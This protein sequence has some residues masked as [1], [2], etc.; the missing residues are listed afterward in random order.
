MKPNQEVA[1]K[2]VQSCS[3]IIQFMFITIIGNCQNCCE[4]DLLKYPLKSISIYCQDTSNKIPYSVQYLY[5]DN[6]NQLLLSKSIS[7]RNS[8]T[9]IVEYKFNKNRLLASKFS[10]TIPITERN[11]HRQR[12]RIFKYD[13]N[14]NLIFDGYEE[15]KGENKGYSENKSY[16]YSK[17]NGKPISSN[18]TYGPNHFENTYEYDSL[19]RLIKLYKNK[20]LEAT[21]EYSNDLLLKETR[22]IKG[23][24]YASATGTRVLIY[25]YDDSGL[26]ILKKQFGKIV[27]KNIYEKGRLLERLT[28][29]YGPD[30]NFS[31]CSSQYDYKFE[32]YK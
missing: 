28:Y 21:Y 12:K 14:N 8:D 7:I 1:N 18:Y 2:F 11:K 23:A 6:N 26:L 10:Y 16:S 17:L 30:P 9:N 27:E 29:Y 24:N 5:Y 22:F 15:G 19:G 20:E 31:T 4:D 13:K 25:E 3:M 32:Y